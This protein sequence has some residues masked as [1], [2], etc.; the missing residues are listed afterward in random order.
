M[1]AI[2]LQSAIIGSVR[3]KVD[4]SLGLSLSTGELSPV[5]KTVFMELMNVPCQIVLTPI[6]EPNAEIMQVDKEA[7][8]KSP[9]QRLRSVLYRVWE[10]N[11][12]QYKTFE[13]YYRIQMEKLIDKLKERLDPLQ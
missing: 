2:K 7:N 5:E 12:R 4:G 9:S 3:A 13:E 8:E 11:P 10:Q 1:K 6:D